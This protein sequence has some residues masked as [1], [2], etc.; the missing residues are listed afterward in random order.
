MS[1]LDMRALR[2]LFVGGRRSTCSLGRVAFWLV[3]G[4]A[5]YFWVV[6]PPEA[7]PE[8]LES[9]LGY[10]L[11]YNLG[12]KAINRVKPYQATS[13]MIKSDQIISKRGAAD[14]DET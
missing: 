11:M 7:F 9:A 8:S 5:V 2:G 3:F 1:W 14:D 4:L 13:N 10:L 6:R 12:G